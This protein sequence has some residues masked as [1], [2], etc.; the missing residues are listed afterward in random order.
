MCSF[1]RGHVRFPEKKN[2][3]ASWWFSPTDGVTPKQRTWM[4]IFFFIRIRLFNEVLMVPLDRRWLFIHLCRRSDGQGTL[5][6]TVPEDDGL[7]YLQRPF[8]AR[9]NECCSYQRVWVGAFYCKQ[10]N[11]LFYQVTIMRLSRVGLLSTF[12]LS[13]IQTNVWRAIRTA[14]TCFCVLW[15]E[16]FVIYIVS[17]CVY[18]FRRIIYLSE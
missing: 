1:Q 8:T 17:I 11:F 13:D 9:S 15:K 3:D 10:P 14:Y 2:N 16:P 5:S 12:I 6:C 7:P 18:S 4:V